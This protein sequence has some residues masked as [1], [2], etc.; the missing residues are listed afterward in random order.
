[1]DSSISVQE[2]IAGF[3]IAA[4]IAII[5][6]FLIVHGLEQSTKYRGAIARR[7]TTSSNRLACSQDK[8]AAYPAVAV[9]GAS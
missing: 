6:V 4:A 9:A 3:V 5:V 1:M 2:M 7:S 8:G